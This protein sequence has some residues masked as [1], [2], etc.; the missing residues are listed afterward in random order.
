MATHIAKSSRAKVNAFAPVH[1]M[2][3]TVADEWPLSTYPEPEVPIK[4]LRHGITLRGKRPR[5]S[6]R[7]R[8]PGVRF[9]HFANNAVLNQTDGEPIMVHGLD[10]NAHLGDQVLATNEFGQLADF[11]QVMRQ[12]F[13]AIHM[14]SELQGAHADW[15]V[16]V[17]G[18]RD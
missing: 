3:I 7:L 1:R 6:P 2:I 5:I 16:H 9:L 17:V 11:V 14:F 13:L 8:N 10:L 18:G 15:G 12:R 4:T